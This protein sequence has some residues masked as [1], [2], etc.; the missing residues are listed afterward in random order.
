MRELII[1]LTLLIYTSSPAQQPV[2]TWMDGSDDV[3]QPGAYGYAEPGA[4]KDFVSWT[5]SNDRLWIF[6]GYANVGHVQG[7]SNNLWRYEPGAG[8]SWITNDADQRPQPNYGERGEFGPGFYPGPR[9]AS[10]S[11]VDQNDHL[12]LFGGYGSDNYIESFPGLMNDLWVY[13][14]ESGEWAWI[15]GSDTVY[16]RGNYDSGPAATPGGRSGSA[17]WV[18]QSG[19]LW[20]FGGSG[21]DARSERKYEH[22]ND[23]WMFDLSTQEW[24]WI[25]GSDTL[26]QPG[27]YGILG[28]ADPANVP[29][30]RHEAVS[31]LDQLGNLWL[32]GGVGYDQ[33]GER[34]IL[35]DLWMF[36]INSEQWTW[37]GGSELY[38]PDPVYGIMGIGSTDNNPGARY[39]HVSW[40]DS[41]GKFWLFGGRGYDSEHEWGEHNDLWKYDPDN[42]EWAWMNGN[43][44]VDQTGSYSGDQ[45]PG[46][47]AGMVSFTT[48]GDKL[49]L[50]GGD[51]FDSQ[52]Y[53]FLLNDLWEYDPLNNTWTW[54]SGSASGNADGYFG[55]PNNGQRI[56]PGARE[57]T[58][59]WSTRAGKMYVFG[60]Y[61]LDISG[62][63]GQLN[64]LWEYDVFTANWTFLKGNSNTDA[65]GYY[66]ELGLRD[67][68]NFPGS[69]SYSATW[70]D[71]SGDLWMFGGATRWWR[72][73]R[74]D[75]WKF[76]PTT[77]RWT[78]MGGSQALDSPGKYSSGL[79]GIEPRPGARQRSAYWKGKDGTLWLFGGFGNDELQAEGYLNDLWKLNPETVMWE[80]ISGNS[81]IGQSGIYGERN[82]GGDQNRPGARESSSFWTD[83]EGNLWL[84]GGYGFD[85]NGALGLLSDLW[86][87]DPE[88]SQWIWVSGSDI[89]DQD[90]VYG[91]LGMANRLNSPG[92]RMLATH[93]KD[94]YGGLWLSGGWDSEFGL[95]NDFWRYDISSNLWTWMAGSND[96]DSFGNYGEKGVAS[97][98]HVPRARTGASAITG[99]DGVAWIFGGFSGIV[100]GFV[101]LTINDLWRIDLI[102]KAPDTALISRRGDLYLEMK[103]DR[104]PYADNYLIE[105]SD[106]DFAS[107]VHPYDQFPTG[108]TTVV[109]RNLEPG[110]SYAFRMKNTNEFGSSGYSSTYTIQTNPVI[111]ANPYPNPA[112]GV[113]NFVIDIP[114]EIQQADIDLGI[115]NLQGMRLATV[116]KTTLSS[117]LHTVQWNPAGMGIEDG[118]YTIRFEILNSA[119]EPVTKKVIIR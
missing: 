64:D 8:W 107:F 100:G 35:N 119:L 103:W 69:R 87:F 115:Y 88:L 14:I 67:D 38:D 68:R 116:S 95:L 75:L 85:K 9:S 55:L 29:G 23:L 111:L 7:Q 34:H 6:G 28:V 57:G 66:G 42:G 78:W 92:G 112:E 94:A 79:N 76:D 102:P 71:D 77:R 104:D 43:N 44:V 89:L 21:M 110:T 84:Y 117:G 99:F 20:L 39:E 18:D 24:H 101:P 91:N 58:G 97:V 16:Q 53:G 73:Q 54:L 62:H 72:D 60:G 98:D 49:Y 13:S 59:V 114:D 17:T 46:S 109:L 48:S 32:F 45:H 30:A 4:R 63:D 40:T 51:G 5:D 96:P 11:W 118:L 22:L 1:I 31:W 41:N 12:W 80:Y 33:I 10:M 26:N 56:L 27:V 86:R 108:D 19:R 50:M 81:R 113:L 25:A 65:E 83:D 74:S 52:D 36:D 90:A 82:Q 15:A 2:F 70:T 47:R 37:M 61:G 105:L 3:N 93:W 106:D